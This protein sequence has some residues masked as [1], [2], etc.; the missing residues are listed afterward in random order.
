MAGLKLFSG[1]RLNLLADKIYEDFQ[2]N[3][4]PPLESE[5]IV[6]QSTGMMKWLSIQLSQRAGIWSN[7]S[8][9]LPNKIVSEILDTVLGEGSRNRFFDKKVM[10]WNTMALLPE[11]Q[12]IESF[13]MISNYLSGELNG[14]K[15][16]QLS[17]KI[18]DTFDQY[19][20][21]RPE[22]I[23]NWDNDEFYS[24][25]DDRDNE[26]WQREI[27]RR[28]TSHRE[29]THPP[30]MLEK[31]YDKIT[32]GDEFDRHNLPGRISVFGISYLPLYH[33]NILRGISKYIDVSFYL[34]NPSRE[35]WYEISN[36]KEIKKIALSSPVV[37]EDPIDELYLERGNPLLA[38]FGKSGKDFYYYLLSSDIFTDY[39]GGFSEPQC[40]SLLGRIQFD[41][42]NMIDRGESGGEPPLTI[43]AEALKEDVSVVVNSC[44]SELREVE[45]LND[46]LLDLFEKNDDLN[47]MD[48]L[49][50]TSDIEKYSSYVNAVLTRNGGTE[51]GIPFSI[52]DRSA[53]DIDR[54]VETF[55]KILELHRDR[56]TSE[57][58]FALISSD[59]L[60]KKFEFSDD[61]IVKIEKWISDT[62]INWGID[63]GYKEKLDL[64]GTEENTWKWAFDRMILG[65]MMNSVDEPVMDVFPYNEVEGNDS[66]I[67]GRLIQC[68]ELLSDFSL[69]MNEEKT[70]P[71]W[72]KI[73]DDIMEKLF[74]V[75][76]SQKNGY[77]DIFTAIDDLRNG[78]ADSDYSAVVPFTV[79]FQY[80]E[81]FL[82]SQ[83]ISN[84][85]I[86]GRVTFCEML[87]MRSIP[88]RAICM[89]G[90]NSAD[91][92]RRSRPPAF[93]LMRAEKRRGDRSIRDEDRYLFLETLMSA[94]DCLYISYVGQNIQDNSE[95][96]P[97][98]VVNELLDYVDSAFAIDGESGARPSEFIH[99]KQRLNP[100]NSFYFSKESPVSYSQENLS[101]AESVIKTE[102]KDEPFFS[103]TLPGLSAEE[104]NITLSDLLSCLIRPS[105][106]LLKRRLGVRYIDPGS[107]S[108]KFPDSEVAYP[109]GLEEYGI[110]DSMLN[111]IAAGVEPEIIYSRLKSLG[112]LPH[113]VSGRVYYDRTFREVNSFYGRV[114]SSIKNK[115]EDFFQTIS[116]DG[117][118]ISNRFSK[119]YDGKNVH[120]RYASFKGKDILR[121]WLEHLILTGLS[122]DEFSGKSI[123]I[124]KDRTVEIRNYNEN[125][126]IDNAMA[127]KYLKNIIE[128]YERSMREAVPLFERSSFEYADTWMN[129]SGAGEK[130]ADALKAARKKFFEGKNNTGD[131]IPG[132]V[133]DRYVTELFPDYVPGKEFEQISLKLYEPLFIHMEEVED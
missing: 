77:G 86:R 72:C 121:L 5:L 7:F 1:N 42:Y 65:S 4:L 40:E 127:R 109:G 83:K 57:H 100:Y 92:P 110:R 13:S 119:L 97:S 122:I 16:Y 102:K 56:F 44:H 71:Q 104:E 113:G 18:V 27:W 82:S 93:D 112:E 103:A 33:F 17:S 101:I 60:R 29:G 53:R 66:T 43:D 21:F 47:P 2:S 124:M 64:P 49:V 63:G 15:A 88:Y 32:A 34:F 85:F 59:D 10:A 45:V 68:V 54:S 94:Q 48:I 74:L 99:I 61:D 70:I 46:F 79:V 3:P 36:D 23:R 30:A 8:Y 89:L 87:P 132:D 55:F 114:A 108:E 39:E 24:K 69:S 90:M 116:V 120:Y 111:W 62:N 95:R 51:K 37:S 11:L 9:R 129:Y 78:V 80:L 35:Y 115:H 52:A 19:M 50:M 125:S 91:F 96:D 130:N 25:E 81:D 133:S 67:L 41:I 22:I 20:T 31:F 117:Y 123:L 28:L 38:S 107:H 6:L 98:I 73:F 76:E 128:I 105:E 75:D 131:V 26:I 106:Y 12:G 126:P 58:I 118:K 14:L 84:D